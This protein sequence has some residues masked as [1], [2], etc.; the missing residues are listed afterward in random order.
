MIKY[1]VCLFF[2]FSSSYAYA[3]ES[4]PWSTTYD[5]DDWTTYAE[6]LDC[7]GL[8]KGLNG[9]CGPSEDYEQITSSANYSGGNGGKGQRHWLGDGKNNSSGGTVIAFSSGQTE[10]WIRL[11][12]RFQSGFTWDLAEASAFKMLY[13]HST[14]HGVGFAPI[15]L[16][17]GTDN[18]SVYTA[19]GSDAHVGCSDCMWTTYSISDGGWFYFEIHIK[20]E[21]V[22]DNDGIMEVWFAPADETPDKIVD[23]TNVDYGLFGD[24]LTGITIGSNADSPNNGECYYVDY[25]DLAIYSQ[26]LPNLDTDGDPFIGPLPSRSVSVTSGTPTNSGAG[27][28]VNVE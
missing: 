18:F 24:T 3:A 2:I 19:F 10:L 6:T 8:S 16:P 4:L 7:S 1:I 12:I 14:N 23:L 20:S 27:T 17:L 22:A 26:S 13:L 15:Y 5:C 9:S 25:D 21:T 11:Y 28:A